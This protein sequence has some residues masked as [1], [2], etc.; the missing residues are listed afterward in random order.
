MSVQARSKVIRQIRDLRGCG[1]SGGR[2]C[3]I[4]QW[5]IKHLWTPGMHAYEGYCPC[6][7][8]YIC[9]AARVDRDAVKFSKCYGGGRSKVL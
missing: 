9:E 6:S 1:V 3:S 7:Q 2:H 8:V 5:L 4:Q